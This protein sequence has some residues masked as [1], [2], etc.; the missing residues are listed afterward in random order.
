MSEN[1]SFEIGQLVCHRRYGYRGVVAARD[2]QCRASEDWYQNNQT[3]PD[4]DQPWYHVL[5]HGGEHTTYVVEENLEEDLGGEQV[6]HPLTRV[7]FEF[8]HSGRYTIREGVRN[9]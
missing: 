9:P 3:Q 8:F 1:Y 6:V 2:P 4:R 5:V 7:I